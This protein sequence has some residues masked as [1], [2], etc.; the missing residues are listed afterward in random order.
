MKTYTITYY[1]PVNG[2]GSISVEARTSLRAQR[3]LM[4][5]LGRSIHTLKVSVN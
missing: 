4:K 5:K 2:K 1:C 3:K